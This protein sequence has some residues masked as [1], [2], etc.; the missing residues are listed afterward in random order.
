MNI[1][2]T[3]SK[4]FLGK[5]I[6]KK[7]EVEGHKVTSFDVVDRL[8]ILNK[9][10][11]EEKLQ[12]IDLCI[13]AAAQACVYEAEKNKN[14]CREINVEGTRNV[15][16][17]CD[18]LGVK[19]VFIS[20]ACIYGNNGEKVQNENSP[21]DPTEIYTETKK[22]GEDLLQKYPSLKYKIVR[23]A[24]FY[25]VGMTKKLAIYKFVDNCKNNKTIE[26][27]G[28]GEQTR[29]YTQ[30]EDTVNGI[31]LVSTLWASDSIYN[32][33]GDDLIS[34]NELISLIASLMPIEPKTKTVDNR[35]GQICRSKIANDKLKALGWKPQYNLK[36]GIAN[37]ID[38]ISKK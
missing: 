12:N 14:K 20:T 1:L 8:D 3:G 15:A 22:E 28:T 27:H 21:L 33:A 4:G 24:T 19:L 17:A 9:K 6:V 35:T 29:S 16:Q 7:F 30:V 31:Y 32:I 36:K 37:Y 23:P 34:V 2:V 10:H 5:Y 25:G 26:I 18:K 13:H 11:I 38:R